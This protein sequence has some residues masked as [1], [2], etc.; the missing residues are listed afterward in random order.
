LLQGLGD[1]AHL[2]WDQLQGHL[3]SRPWQAA[4]RAADWLR[5]LPELA[6]LIRLRE[7]P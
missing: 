5:Q 4:R 6:E 3:R 7:A 2:R 1:F